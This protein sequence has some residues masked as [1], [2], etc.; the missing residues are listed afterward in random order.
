M[1]GK[2]ANSVDINRF[3]EKMRATFGKR[4]QTK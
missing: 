2:N 4:L 3:F 1:E